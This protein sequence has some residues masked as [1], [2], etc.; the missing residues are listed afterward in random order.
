M[1][2]VVM[3]VHEE[4]GKIVSKNCKRCGELKLTED[5]AVPCGKFFYAS[6]CNACH[7]YRE[8]QIEL[9]RLIGGHK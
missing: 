8:E 9:D 1:R 6:L 5:F 4:S 3:Y 2:K 7:G